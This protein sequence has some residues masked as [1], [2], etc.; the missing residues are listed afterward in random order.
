MEGWRILTTCGWKCMAHKS[1][2][3]LFKRHVFI[4]L[5]FLNFKI[6]FQFFLILFGYFKWDFLLLWPGARPFT[7]FVGL[8]EFVYLWASKTEHA[9]VICTPVIRDTRVTF[10]NFGN[11]ISYYMIFSQLFSNI[12]TSVILEPCYRKNLM[13][14]RMLPL[15]FGILGSQSRCRTP[16]LSTVIQRRSVKMLSLCMHCEFDTHGSLHRRWLSRN[17]NKMQLCNR[18]YY[19]KVF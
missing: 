12:F 13:H 7:F 9:V 16:V 17:T 14:V 4:V 6:H 8:S 3:V 15:D 2:Y 18:I 1:Y 11:L 19:S 10:I 5:W